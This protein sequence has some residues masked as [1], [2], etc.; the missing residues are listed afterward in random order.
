DVVA[1]GAGGDQLLV[2]RGEAGEAPDGLDGGPGRDTA[3]FTSA[4]APVTADL[5]AG[6]ARFGDKAVA[7]AGIEALTGSFFADRLAGGAGD[8]ALDGS[9]GTD[10]LDGRGG[11]D[12]LTGGPDPDTVRGGPGDDRLEADEV[13]YGFLDPDPD[14]LNRLDCGAGD[15][16]V[17]RLGDRDTVRASCER[18]AG[19]RLLADPRRPA[20][21]HLSVRR[22]SGR[23]ILRLDAVTGRGRI[24]LLT[25]HYAPPARRHRVRLG[26]HARAVLRREHARR[27]LVRLGDPR[28]EGTTPDRFFLRLSP[29]D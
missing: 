18:F 21:A 24:H 4:P 5:A 2:S 9:H 16:T 27:L 6:T 10:V 22:S 25:R 28:D 7:L 8:D 1:G 20:P 23:P 11:D 26:G 19:Y 12:D 29:T 3:S 15:D 17:G 13:P 14:P